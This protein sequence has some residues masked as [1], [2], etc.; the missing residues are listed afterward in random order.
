MDACIYCSSENYSIE[1]ELEDIYNETHRM[2]ECE[3][4]GIHYLNPQ[5]TSSQL[6]RAYS[7]DYYGLGEK[8]FGQFT[9]RIVDWFRKR[10]AKHFSN[11]LKTG[12]KILDVGCGNG[13]FL[14]YLGRCGAFELYGIEPEGKSADRASSYPEIKL[15]RGYLKEG[16]FPNNYFDAIVFTHVFE[17]LGNPA[18]VLKIVQQISKPGTILRIEIPNI[19]SW[20][21]SIFKNKWFHLDPPRH[22]NMFPSDVLIKELTRLGWK[23]EK[24]NYFSPQFSPFGMQ[25]S[26][27]NL[28]LKKRDVLYEYLKGNQEYIKEYSRGAIFLQ[29]LFHWSSFPFFV[30]TDII[31]SL[32]RKGAIVKLIFK[33]N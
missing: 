3:N 2:C 17:H 5:P 11:K 30:I 13:S 19:N 33:K 12:A 25:Q 31:A 1:Y 14:N 24:E 28:V 29:Q 32:F 23:L 10:N 26:F 22:L 18:E 16:I 21:A 6:N 20:Q 27:L 8:K 15:T 7:E 9:E 4:C